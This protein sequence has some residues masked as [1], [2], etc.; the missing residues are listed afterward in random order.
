MLT[1]NFVRLRYICFAILYESV[2]YK[3]VTVNKFN[4]TCCKGYFYRSKIL[5][6]NAINMGTIANAVLEKFLQV[7]VCN[8]VSLYNYSS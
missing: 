2:Q 7:F 3:K 1:G 5:A 6:K 8:N 4:M